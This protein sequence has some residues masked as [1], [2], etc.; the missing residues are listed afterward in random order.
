M[1][2][3]VLAATTLR[4]GAFG[5]PFNMTGRYVEGCACPAPCLC[6]MTGLVMGCEGVGTFEFT[7]GDVG[8]VSIANCRGAY[9][10]APG[11]WVIIY[12]DAP[13][14]DQ[15]KAV[16]R[17]MRYSLDGFGKVEAVRSA[18]ITLAGSNGNFK[19]SV[20]SYYTLS[21][22]PMVGGDGKTALKYG[23]LHDRIHPDVM[24]GTTVACTFRDGSHS[25]KLKGSNAFFNENLAAHGNL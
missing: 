7:S 10:T 20:G 23:N 22:K 8:G 6:E 9:A 4:A 11:K 5:T 14:G 21:S 2:L 17:M 12:V 25:F 15:R 16:E 19:T 3:A 13:T 1:L 24:G 18:K